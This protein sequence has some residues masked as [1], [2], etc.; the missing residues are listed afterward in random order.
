MKPSELKGKSG[1][2]K[3][4][5]DYKNNEKQNV[6]LDGKDTEVYTPFVMMTGMK[7]VAMLRLITEKLFLMEARIS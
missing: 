5:V 3:I 2:L 4:T 1:H 6:S 7:H